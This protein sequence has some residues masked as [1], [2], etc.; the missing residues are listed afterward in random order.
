MDEREVAR[1]TERLLAKAAGGIAIKTRRTPVG[2]MVT[3]KCLVCSEGSTLVHD[4]APESILADDAPDPTLLAWMTAFATL[5]AHE[6][7]FS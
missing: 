4:G 7:R 6:E 1:A 5:H 2:V 3:Q